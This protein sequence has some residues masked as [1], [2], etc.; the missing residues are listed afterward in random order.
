MRRRLRKAHADLVMLRV[1]LEKLVAGANMP[2]ISS[3]NEY[4]ERVQNSPQLPSF[5]LDT[6]WNGLKHKIDFATI[7]VGAL[8]DEVDKIRNDFVLKDAYRTIQ[9]ALHSR[10]HSY[11]RSFAH[12]LGQWSK[13]S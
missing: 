9:M 13:T 6:W 3:I 2:L 11:L 10:E 8:L 1:N 7:Q 12:Y 5:V 4:V